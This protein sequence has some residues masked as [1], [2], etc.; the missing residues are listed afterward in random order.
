M[1]GSNKNLIQQFSKKLEGIN[2]LR[3]T[4]KQFGYFYGEYSVFSQEIYICDI[5]HR[6]NMYVVSQLYAFE[7]Q[8]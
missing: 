8:R 3:F 1:D 7:C 6:V 5:K 2:F 4:F